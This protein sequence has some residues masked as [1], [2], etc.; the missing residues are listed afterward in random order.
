MTT[1]T[2][3]DF[4]NKRGLPLLL[5][6]DAVAPTG[7]S[8]PLAPGLTIELPSSAAHYTKRLLRSGYVNV[9]DEARKKWETYFVTNDAYFF[10]VMGKPGSTPIIPK[11]PFNCS[12]DR[13]RSVAA[14]ITVADPSNA[15]KVWVGFSDVLW[16]A[17]VRTA[18]ENSA[19]RKR[20]MVEIDV[21]G[22]LKGNKAP[23]KSINQVPIMV[24]EYAM[25]L[26]N[27]E[28]GFSSSPFKPEARF[29]RAEHL[30]K[31]CHSMYAEKGLIVTVPD[32]VGIVQ[33]LALIMQEKIKV[34]LAESPVDQRNLAASVA[35]DNMEIGIRN[36]SEDI[37]ISETDRLADE[38]V[39]A[40]PIGH[41]L[42]ESTRART[43]RLRVITSG[44]LDRSSNDGWEKY[45]KKFDNKSRQAWLK[46]FNQRFQAF[47]AESIAPLAVSHAGWMRSKSVADYFECNYDVQNAESG[48]VYTTVV[49]QC[50]TATQDKQACS[51]LYDKWLDGDVSD[52]GN[53]LLRA[54]ISNQ[55]TVEEAMKK[56]EK[57][58]AD[59]LDIPW[60][61]ILSAYKSAIERLGECA[62]DA[63]A[64][65]IVQIGGPLARAFNKVLD[66]SAGFRTAIMATGLIS[67]HPIVFIEVTGSRKQFRKLA[68]RELLRASG[69]TVNNKVMQKAVDVQL[70]KLQIR[71]VR[72]DGTT[73]MRFA[74][75][76]D[77]VTLRTVPNGLSEQ[78]M[79][80]HLASSFR[81]IDALQDLNLNRWRSVIN[82]ETGSTAVGA[83]LQTITLINLLG[84][85]EKSL[86]HDK[87]NASKRVNAG[88]LGIIGSTSEIL[89]N[90]VRDR[91][92]LGVRFGQGIASNMGRYTAIAGR[93]TG[94]AGGLY[95]AYLDMEQYAEARN[96]NQH[97]LA[98]LYASSAVAGIA[99]TSLLFY[100]AWLGA[101]AIP[102]I[103]LLI[104]LCIGIGVLIANIAD[105]R[106]QDWLE[107]CPWGILESQRYPDMATEQAQLELALN[108]G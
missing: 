44:E 3:C 67:G 32:P 11:N 55:K 2:K 40:N 5:V 93:F 37:E 102:V 72:L 70:K 12:N 83:I 100:S 14:C 71:G 82:L 17:A 6:R 13:H 62:Q 49:C 48:A 87:E 91:A 9:F 89:G 7:A 22:V 78:Q 106:I 25:T 73:K 27:A 107:R 41:L 95:M 47:N 68:V 54:M 79:A 104:L 43:E 30:I 75:N 18:N 19:Y 84:E 99:L 60:D 76:M 59:V 103:G 4:C 50:L 21:Q 52:K 98:W 15:T 108:K 92:N 8:A 80:T 88:I 29:G 34:F 66:G 45:V 69:Q 64:K 51:R 105:N 33:E 96:E 86:A 46:P 63:A 39:A 81:T 90:F 101:A 53:I 56:A 23:H 58:S 65:L 61:N 38:E 57:E 36:F 94:L 26:K 42:F 97:G 77:A 85:K 74:L 31:E 1:P 20:H 16:T 24:A 28:S 35:I 10:K